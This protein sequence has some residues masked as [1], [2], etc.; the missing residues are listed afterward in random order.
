MCQE[1][2]LLMSL[3]MLSQF[4]WQRTCWGERSP[5]EGTAT[6]VCVDMAP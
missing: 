3:E 6:D 5:R 2:N 1:Q 4:K